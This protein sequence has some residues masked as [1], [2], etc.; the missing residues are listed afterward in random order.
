MGRCISGYLS[1]MESDRPEEEHEAKAA[2][3]RRS[4]R[5][6]VLAIETY[7]ATR[8]TKDEGAQDKDA[9]PDEKKTGLTQSVSKLRPQNP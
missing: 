1:D 7:L 3:Q 4:L 6:A 8:T 5:S 2:V 9:P